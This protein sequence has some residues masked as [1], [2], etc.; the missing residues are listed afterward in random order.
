MLSI[1]TVGGGVDQAAVGVSS[2]LAL[3]QTLDPSFV[4]DA[5]GAVRAVISFLVMTLFGYI[6]LYAYRSRIDRAVDASMERPLTST[7][8]GVM[9]YGVVVFLVGYAYSQLS[10]LGIGTVPLSVLAAGVLAVILLTLG[11]F[12]FTV[13]GTIL[14][15]A[16]GRRDPRLGLIGVSGVSSVAWLLLPFVLGLVVWLGF[17]AV[18][19]GGAT[20]R[21]VHVGDTELSS[22]S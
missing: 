1:A 8:Y 19:I 16:V 22:A 11:G 20:R 21:W 15:E 9:A 10:R 18:G 7:L 13:A 17:A 12:G 14:T 6:A 2:W 3:G 5:P 4:V